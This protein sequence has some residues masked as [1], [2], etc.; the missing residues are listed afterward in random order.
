MRLALV[1]SKYIQCVV[2]KLMKMDETG[3]IY[4]KEVQEVRFNWKTFAKFHEMK[5]EIWAAYTDF[6]GMTQLFIQK[7]FIF[8]NFILIPV[9]CDYKGV[10]ETQ[11]STEPVKGEALEKCWHS[12]EIPLKMK[13]IESSQS[14]YTN[15]DVVS[16]CLSVIGMRKIA[17]LHSVYNFID[18]CF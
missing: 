11:S 4:F 13:L 17:R 12:I 7:C 8:Q 3:H 10:Y 14:T 18:K 16:N 6:T 15:A 9:Q 2:H 5:N 1:K